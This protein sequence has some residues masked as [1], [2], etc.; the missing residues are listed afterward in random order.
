MK[1]DFPDLKVELYYA[2]WDATDRVTIDS[3]PG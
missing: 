3:I 2:G 1:R